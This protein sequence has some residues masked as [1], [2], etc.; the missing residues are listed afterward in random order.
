MESNRTFSRVDRRNA[1]RRRKRNASQS[2]EISRLPANMSARQ[3]TMPMTV[4]YP[5]NCVG[6][7]DRLIVVLKYAQL[8]N[9]SGSAAPS[10]QTFAVNSAFDPDFSGTGHQPSFYD[11]YSAYYGRYFVRAF[12]VEFEVVT[13][14]ST[15]PIQVAAVYSDTNIGANTVEELTE[16]KYSLWD[17]L[18][19]NS[20]GNAVRRFNMPWMSTMKIM[21]QPNSEAD[22]N[23]YAAVSASPTDIAFCHIKLGATDLTTTVSA[24]ARCTLYQEVIFKDLLPQSSS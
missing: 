6:A 1:Q 18:S 14:V 22:D 15:V 5:G 17:I 19:I 12:K 21:G 4:T 23:M 20:G 2:R 7:P 16:S 9:F 13:T 3:F 11:R 24:T 10:A 8:I